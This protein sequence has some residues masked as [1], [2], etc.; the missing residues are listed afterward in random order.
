VAT[1]TDPLP[2]MH[3]PIPTI[4]ELPV[5]ITASTGTQT[6]TMPIEKQLSPRVMLSVCTQTEVHS[7]IDIRE[8]NFDSEITES[9]S[10]SLIYD[11]TD[12]NI[13]IEFRAVEESE[14]MT[15][16]QL[17]E[18]APKEQ[19]TPINYEPI[20][21]QPHLRS[22]KKQHK[23]TKKKRTEKVIK[24]ENQEN[25]KPLEVE[26]VTESIPKVPS[27]LVAHSDDIQDT[28]TVQMVIEKKDKKTDNLPTIAT[29]P[30]VKAKKNKK[31]RTS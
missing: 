25:A 26:K 3:A 23:T 15:P 22:A 18:K 21:R 16:T 30:H 9:K 19:E 7:E 11:Y 10:Q 20:A 1:Q 24:I 28:Q 29:T 17:V 12:T 27:L 13:D 14:I 4:T 6:D 5:K 31:S 2:Q 8:I